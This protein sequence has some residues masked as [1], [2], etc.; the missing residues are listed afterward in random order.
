[1]ATKMLEMTGD[2]CKQIDSLNSENIA[3]ELKCY[4]LFRYEVENF[5][6]KVLQIYKELEP[7]YKELHA[8]IR[9]KLS[10]KYGEVYSTN[11]MILDR[12]F[13]SFT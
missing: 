11:R 2:H 6:E 7:L 9:R 12:E 13:Y 1:M 10:E 3:E 5:E 8:Y 4:I